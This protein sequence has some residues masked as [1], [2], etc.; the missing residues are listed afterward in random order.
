MVKVNS[1]VLALLIAAGSHIQL[2]SSYKDKILGAMEPN[3]LI[4]NGS[5][6]FV[7]QYLLSSPLNP[8]E[9]ESFGRDFKSEYP[10]DNYFAI[11]VI[12]GIPPKAPGEKGYEKIGKADFVENGYVLGAKKKKMEQ[13][14]RWA[15]FEQ[16][17]RAA[18]QAQVQ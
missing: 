11:V 15:L 13:A 1:L 5:K 8:Q 9:L 17:K 3:L 4:V 2:S 18:R 6:R 12:D 14:I 7:A 16:V 10:Q